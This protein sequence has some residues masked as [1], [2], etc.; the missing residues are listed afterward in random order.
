MWER[1]IEKR[2][3]IIIQ[4]DRDQ[5]NKINYEMKCVVRWL[6]QNIIHFRIACEDVTLF[7]IVRVTQLRVDSVLIPYGTTNEIN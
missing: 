1:R 5:S 2:H 4:R 6:I 3:N 7:S